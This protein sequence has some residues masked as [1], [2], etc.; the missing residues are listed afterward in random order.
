MRLAQ[1]KRTSSRRG[2][3]L[4]RKPR[5]EPISRDHR[6]PR[7]QSGT[8]NCEGARK[9]VMMVTERLARMAYL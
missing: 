8:Q 3:L 7:E 6:E 2:L 4:R 1:R 9:S 5:R